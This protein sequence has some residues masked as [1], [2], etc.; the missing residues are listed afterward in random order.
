MPVHYDQR[1][2]LEH[3]WERFRYILRHGISLVGRV[4]RFLGF[5]NSSLR[6]QT[7]WFMAPFVRDRGL[8]DPANL[9][10]ELGDFSKLRSP[11]KCAARIGQAFSDTVPGVKINKYSEIPDVKRNE[12]TFSDGCGTVSQRLLSKIWRTCS[13][14]SIAQANHLPVPI[15]W[16]QGRHL[17]GPHAS[18]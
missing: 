9:I 10:K 12:R 15:C 11:A 16:S 14:W 2:S 7:I 3:V 13:P 18:G 8:M 17:A 4:Y 5:S 6:S 1:A